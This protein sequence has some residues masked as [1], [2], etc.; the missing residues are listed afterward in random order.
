MSPELYSKL[1][2]W[3]LGLGTT[4][5]IWCFCFIVLSWNLTCRANN[6][7]RIC[8]NHIS[9]SNNALVIHFAQQKGD[10]LG[11]TTQFPRHL[12]ANPTNHL[13]CPIFALG[14]YLMTFGVPVNH[15]AQ[16]FP[17]SNQYK[18][19]SR[20]LKEILLAHEDSVLV[21]GYQVADIGTHSIWKEE[22]TFISS[23]PGGPLPAAICI[24]GGW[25]LGGVK[26]VHTKYETK[27]DA[28]CGRL[29]TLLNIW[30]R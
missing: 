22:T 14:L 26:D 21:L 25:S 16:L 18:R 10:Q 13:A 8:L 2:E 19:F 12:Y 27:G 9:W 17:G 24:R 6:T 7:S 4:E 5:G 15:N 11:L 20:M 1:C 29:L 3:F 30:G 28:F 23:L